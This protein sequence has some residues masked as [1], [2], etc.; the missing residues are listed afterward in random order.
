MVYLDQINLTQSQKEQLVELALEAVDNLG[1]CDEGLNVLE[2]MGFEVPKEDR[3]VIL[4]VRVKGI[5]RGDEDDLQ[6]SGNWNID[7]YSIGFEEVSIEDV[8]VE[9]V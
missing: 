7:L 3:T 9:D 6:Y 1:Y 2:E 4:T 8:S 5:D